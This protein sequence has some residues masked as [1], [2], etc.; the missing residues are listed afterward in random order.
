MAAKEVIDIARSFG[1]AEGHFADKWVSRVMA[2]EDPKMRLDI[3]DECILD[4]KSGMNAP[5]CQGL[6][7]ALRRFRML[8]AP[9]TA[10]V[11]NAK[12]HVRA[13]AMKFDAAKKR[14]VELWIE[15]GA[16]LA[17]RGPERGSGRVLGHGVLRR[18]ALPGLLRLRGSPPQL[19]KRRGPLGPR[20]GVPVESKSDL[21]AYA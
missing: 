7:K 17:R 15:G 5:D 19:Q 11:K 13:L 21:R 20:L 6:D 16:R 8:V 1:S 12:Q 14:A 4:M 3:L 9:H 2:T 18:R 10:L